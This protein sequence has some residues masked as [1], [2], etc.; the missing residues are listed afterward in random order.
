AR[1]CKGPVK[2][3]R[4]YQD[5]KDKSSTSNLK[6]HAIGCWGKAAVDDALTG[7]VPRL[8]ENAIH[9]AF[10]KAS[11]LTVDHSVQFSHWN[12]SNAE[13][14]STGR[15]NIE[16]PS[17]KTVSRDIKAAFAH[18][19]ECIK[20]ILTDHPGRVHFATDAWTSPNHRAFVA[21]TVHFEFQGAPLLFLLDIVEVPEV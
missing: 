9:V 14:M 17:P 12:H 5:S 8:R 7:K 13:L 15:P 18:C 10:A 19:R 2:G 21:W 11:G 3:V 4:R 1:K 20:K 16:I 6:T